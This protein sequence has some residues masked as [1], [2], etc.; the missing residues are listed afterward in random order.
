MKE[1]K[2]P[3]GDDFLIWKPKEDFVIKTIYPKDVKPLENPEKAVEEAINNPLGSRKLDE[4]NNV[5]TVAIAISDLTRPVPNKIILP[6]LIEKLLSMGIKP[7]NICILIG[8]GLHRRSNKEEFVK[9]IGEELVNKVTVYSHDANDDNLLVNCGTTKRGTPVLVNRYFVEADLKI[10]TG[11]IDPHHFVGYTGGAKSLAIGLGGKKLIDKNHSMLV[12]DGAELGKIDGN[13][14]R[15]DIDEIGRI[16]GIDFMLNV[17]LNNDRKIVGVVGGDYLEAHKKGVQIARSIFEVHVKETADV[18]LTSPGGFP[19]DLNAYQAQKGLAHAAKIVKKGGYL[20]LLA[21][22]NE[23]HG[24]QKFF[25]TMKSFSK[26]EEVVEG[27]KKRA[28]EVGPHKA[29]LWARSLIKA[30]AYLISDGIDQQTA[31]SLMVNKASSIEE[32]FLEI[33]NKLPDNP[34]VYVMPKA[35]STVPVIK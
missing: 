31:G 14:V 15:E 5:K 9:L 16:V 19:K 18:V 6:P 23:G 25:D 2:I 28:F 24:D 17:V 32:V 11:M 30:N 21:K 10:V 7:K 8:T 27:F 22:C 35:N 29:L 20:I 4:F 1:I 12:E 33:K 26:P 34:I 13:P 3:Y